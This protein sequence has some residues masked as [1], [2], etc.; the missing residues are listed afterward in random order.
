MEF[1]GVWQNKGKSY[2]DWH[3]HG[4]LVVPKLVLPEQQILGRHNQNIYIY[5]PLMLTISAAG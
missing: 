1:E 5:L 2:N 3:V 4:L